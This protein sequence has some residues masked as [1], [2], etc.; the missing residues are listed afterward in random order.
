MSKLS[1]GIPIAAR[2]LLAGALAAGL[3]APTQASDRLFEE[4]KGRYQFDR[5]GRPVVLTVYVEEGKLMVDEPRFPP[6]E[7]EVEDRGR[8]RFRAAHEKGVYRFRFI[9]GADG[10]ISDCVWS[11]GGRRDSG[12]RSDGI[13]LRAA[14]SRGELLQD[15]K[16]LRAAMESLHP[17]LY[18]YTPREEFDRLFTEA[19]AALRGGTGLEAAYRIFAGLTSRI[20]CMHSSIWMPRGYWDSLDGRLFPLRLLFSGDTVFVNGS[21]TDGPPIPPGARVHAING[22]PIEEILPAVRGSIS[23]DARSVFY[24]NYRLSFRFPLHY[25]LCFG[26]PPDFEVDYSLPGGDRRHR[27]VLDPV[28]TAKV[29]KNMRRPRDLRFEIRDDPVA[30]I[31]VIPHFAYYR[32]HEKFFGFLEKAFDEIR[33]RGIEDLIIDLRGND[34]GDPFCAARLF[35]YLARES[36]PYFSRPYGRYAKLADPVPLRKNRFT[37]RLFVLIDGGCGSTTGHLAGLLAYHGLGVRIGETTGATY[38]CHDAHRSFLLEHTRF[39][40]GIATGTFASAV[41]GLARDRGIE[42]HHAVRP[43]ARDLS[44]GK[45]TV[46]EY[47]LR[48]VR[49]S[50]ERPAGPSRSKRRRS[51]PFRMNLFIFNLLGGDHGIIPRSDGKLGGLRKKSPGIRNLLTA[52]PVYL[53]AVISRTRKNQSKP[54]GWRNENPVPIRGDRAAGGGK[55]GRR[56][57]RGDHSQPHYRGNRRGLVDRRGLHAAQPFGESRIPRDDH[58]RSHLGEGGQEEKILQADA[59]GPESPGLRQADP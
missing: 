36:V 49:G 55:T 34:G 14:L 25:A 37:G 12:F 51:K 5:E 2:L 50:D 7:L 57:L 30:A 58:R 3:S 42:P 41:E 54:G 21:Y 59:S 20:G 8:L 31:I 13:R 11:H 53:N 32:D 46:L 35:A 33:R 17:A 4:I 24:M 38:V 56:R 28:P 19:R 6:A 40:A 48:L 52:N 15:L 45:D 29:W 23:A 18:D 1:G 22:R 10:K 43:A 39:Q 47:A 27:A 9:R 26:H 44:E 16:Q